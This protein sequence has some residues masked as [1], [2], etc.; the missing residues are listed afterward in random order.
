[1][2]IQTIEQFRQIA[3]RMTARAQDLGLQSKT[4]TP[5]VIDQL[6]ELL[7][8]GMGYRNAHVARSQVS[9]AAATRD[10]A[11]V[12]SMKAFELGLVGYQVM[13][14]APVFDAPGNW[15]WSS[16]TG[17]QAQGFDSKFDAVLAAW[18]HAVARVLTATGQDPQKWAA[19][20]LH[21]QFLALQSALGAPRTVQGRFWVDALAN[22][23]Q[24]QG[25]EPQDLDDMVHEFVG[26]SDHA[27][28]VNNQGLLAQVEALWG[29]MHIEGRTP[30]VSKA[31]L[32]GRL[33][34]ECEGYV[35]AFEGRV[36]CA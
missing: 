5:L 15:C 28:W 32:L 30:E 35:P 21:Q 12:M 9:Q 8:A 31:I 2:Q 36:L 1:M 22:D 34:R 33:K 19:R 11:E 24:Q 23:L 13:P 27:S 17:A 25:F 10:Y 6:E 4:G 18:D 3:A 29:A 16:S 26:P 7:A 20:P 14:V